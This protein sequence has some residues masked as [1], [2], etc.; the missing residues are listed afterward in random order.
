[1]SPVVKPCKLYC[2][3]N[4]FVDEAKFFQPFAL[5]V[6]KRRMQWLSKLWSLK[7][8]SYPLVN[9]LALML[10]KILDILQKSIGITRGIRH[11]Q[12]Q[13]LAELR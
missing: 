1:M 4:Y 11:L 13:L 9:K 3:A 8:F 2:L 7:D 6:V 12:I 10:V 5:V